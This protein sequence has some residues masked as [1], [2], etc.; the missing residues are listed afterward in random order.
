MDA[1]AAGALGAPDGTEDGRVRR[2]AARSLAPSGARLP[3]LPGTV[4]PGRALRPRTAGRLEAA[5]AIA[6]SLGAVQYRHVRDILAA[7]RDRIAQ[8]RPTEWVSP[9]HDNV[10]GAAYYH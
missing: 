9:A 8:D 4:E 3:Q 1:R 6:L 7:G 5:C 2:R 10:R